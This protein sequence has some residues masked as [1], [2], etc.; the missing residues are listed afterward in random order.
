[1]T[2]YRRSKRHTLNKGAWI[3][4]IFATDFGK[5]TRL[6]LLFIWQMQSRVPSARPQVLQLVRVLFKASA[7][8]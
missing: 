7:E 4:G 2:R 1:M 5:N 3:T 6:R 8:R